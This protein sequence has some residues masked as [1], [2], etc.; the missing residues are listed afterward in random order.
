MNKTPVSILQEMMVKKSTVPN[1]ELI[2]DGGG[3]HMNTFTYKVT[4]DGLSAIGTGRSKK[5]AKHEAA[6]EMLETIAAHR[7]YP[8]LLA[9]PAQSPVRTP[10]P[11][12]VPEVPR[13]PPTE[14][15][16]NAIGALQDLCAENNL[17]EPIYVQISDV[18]PPHAKIFTI[19]CEVSTFK[20][21]GV[22]K[23]KKQ[24]KQEAAKKMLD[25]ISDLV[26]NQDGN[27][28]DEFD[29][30]AK[31]NIANEL[32]KA[33]Y[34]LLTR[35]S[36]K[37][38]QLGVKLS[39]FHLKIKNSFPSDICNELIEKLESL[40]PED[41][42]NVSEEDVDKL[43]NEFSEFLSTLS[44]SISTMTLESC[45]PDKHVVLMKINTFPEITQI[46][47]ENIIT[48]ARFFATLNL[49]NTMLFLLK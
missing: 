48:K 6:K 47:C 25:K 18:G 42:S 36:T 43:F 41:Q 11:P 3:T 30:S 13:I 24:A 9:S 15:F 40:I 1:Y 39:E 20:E 26:A 10:L 19:Q 21:I 46:S 31:E 29:D 22:A 28:S 49:I 16:V 17:Q 37:K 2:H 33:R 23:T 14:P 8:Q 38:V 35:L 7:G 12:Q 5:D 27:L 44:L 4:C 32:A 45:I 34:P